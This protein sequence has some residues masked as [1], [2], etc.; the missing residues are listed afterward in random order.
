MLQ[1]IVNAPQAVIPYERAAI[2]L[3][4]RGR[5]KLSA[6]TGLTQVNAD[7][8]DVAPLNEILQW[9][10]L[11]E[12]V[13]HVRQVGEEVDAP[14]EETRAK[15]ARYFKE[16]G[17]R[18]FYS[19]PLS[20]DTGRVGILG[21]ES[22][23]PDFLSPAHIEILEVLAGQATVALRNAQMYKEVP[24]ISVL[25]PVLERKRKFMA[26]E[27]KRR[28]LIIAIAAAAVI[29]LGIFPLP[30]RVDG[31]AVVAPGHRAQVQPEIEGI[32]GK[33]YVREGQAVV[34]GQVLADME[35]W[36]YRSAL[37]E[38]EAK[39]RTAVLQVN[40][41][42][43]GN[44]TGEAGLQRVQADYWKTEVD[45]AKELLNRTQLRAPIDGVISTPHIENAVGRHLQ[46]GESFAE[47]LDSSQAIVDVAVDDVDAGLVRP[48]LRA[49]LK[50]NSYATRTFRG[51]VSIVSPRAETQH[52]ERVFFARVA[53]ENPDGSLRT[54]MEGRGKVTV[55]WFPS[56]YVFFRRP[57]LWAYSKMWAWFGW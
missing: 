20:D 40:H 48:G 3:E 57:V 51:N 45:R 14:R 5:F 54:G 9:A 41:S 24:F 30:L 16:T 35:A 19:M 36:D 2:A 11:S 4:Q 43:A 10:A 29:F 18:A 22:D 12:E 38:A 32:I 52:D 23:D 33:V 8:P 25:E 31:D 56:G 6:V 13:I 1:T 39:Y 21:L 34:Q 44:D 55:G 37:A 26:M 17:R 46:H 15:F 28:G 42:L 27:K 53:L 7:D 49:V 47:I 50:L